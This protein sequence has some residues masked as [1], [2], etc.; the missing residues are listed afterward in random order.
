MEYNSVLYLMK[1]RTPNKGPPIYPAKA[2]IYTSE[3]LTSIYKVSVI[4][5]PKVSLHVMINFI[6][7]ILKK[8]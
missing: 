3:A 6:D 1:P 2:K 8:S 5:S 4:V 7:S